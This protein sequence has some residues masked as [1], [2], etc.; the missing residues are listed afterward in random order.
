MTSEVSGWKALVELETSFEATGEEWV[1]RGQPS[2]SLRLK[3]TLERACEDFEVDNGAIFTIENAIIQD[4]RRLCRP[5]STS[6]SLSDQDTIA[7]VALMRHHG[8]PVRLLDFTFS[9][10][11]AAYF[12]CEV[13]RA[14][15]VVWAVNKT[16]LTKQYRAAVYAAYPPEEAEDL[17]DKWGTREGGVFDKLFFSREPRFRC[18]WPVGPFTFNDRLAAQQGLF[19]CTNDIQCPFQDALDAMPDSADNVKMVP[20]TSKAAR[21]EILRKLH[22]TRLSRETLFPGFQGFAESLRSK[23]PLIQALED[24]RQRGTRLGPNITGV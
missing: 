23:I 21:C 4:F 24:M 19:L 18:V 15:P 8:A 12:A 3:T 5:Y 7:W 2:P 11:I 6:L 20:I 17:L 13:E 22:R 14:Q 9:L 16:W 1:F 10:F